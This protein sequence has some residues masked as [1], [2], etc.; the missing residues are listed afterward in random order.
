[1]VEM[2]MQCIKSPK[3]ILASH[4]H[5]MLNVR[6]SSLYFP[7]ENDAVSRAAPDNHACIG[8]SVSQLKERSGF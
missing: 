7:I 2:L 6:R 3:V 8:F 4:L 1:M 5:L